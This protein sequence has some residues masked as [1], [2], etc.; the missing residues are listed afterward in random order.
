MF[1]DV[2][3]TNKNKKQNKTKSPKKTKI[4]AWGTAQHSTVLMAQLHPVCSH[5]GNNVINAQW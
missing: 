1:L 3:K 5:L 4:E 2:N